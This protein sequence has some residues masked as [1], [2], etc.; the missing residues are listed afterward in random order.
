MWL[1]KGRQ[2]GRVGEDKG[3]W[4]STRVGASACTVPAIVAADGHFRAVGRQSE[5]RTVKTGKQ[6][7]HSRT[8]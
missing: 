1:S 4:W 3:A 7:D 6:K 2:G 8:G 5:E